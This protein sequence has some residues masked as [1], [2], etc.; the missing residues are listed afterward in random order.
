MPTDYCHPDAFALETAIVSRLDDRYSEIVI[1][2]YEV[3]GV[4]VLAWH[5]GA[6]AT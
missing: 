2:D 3:L 4:L 5:K 1:S 6:I